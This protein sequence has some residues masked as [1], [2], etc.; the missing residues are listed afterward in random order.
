MGVCVLTY[1]LHA[2]LVLALQAGAAAGMLS[3]LYTELQLLQ[4][5]RHGAP[6]LGRKAMPYVT[7]CLFAFCMCS[8]REVEQRLVDVVSLM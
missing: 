4:Q 1:G 7:G 2:S 6:A 5:L 3:V 8:P